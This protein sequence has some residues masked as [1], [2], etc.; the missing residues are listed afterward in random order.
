[1][2]QVSYG[3]SAGPGLAV[4]VMPLGDTQQVL[5]PNDPGGSNQASQPIFISGTPLQ[6]PTINMPPVPDGSTN[7]QVV[8]TSA[9][10]AATPV[11]VPFSLTGYLG[12]VIASPG[13][14]LIAVGVLLLLG[15]WFYKHVLK[16]F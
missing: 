13:Q 1:M 15:W 2:I 3:T 9:V 8:G 5:D 7:T 6:V 4:S 10:P 16:K 14:H 11:A 12:S